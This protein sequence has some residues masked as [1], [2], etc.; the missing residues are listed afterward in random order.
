M[1]INING[2]STLCKAKYAA[3]QSVVEYDD[4]IHYDFPFSEMSHSFWPKSL[5]TYPQVT[6][7]SMARSRCYLSSCI[8][9]Y[10]AECFKI[11]L[12]SLFNILP[13]RSIIFFS[14]IKAQSGILFE[15]FFEDFFLHTNG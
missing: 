6:S 4:L 5:T 15:T 8:P 2:V 1:T 11:V 7:S 12:Q 14:I 3:L 9:E 13:L 10:L